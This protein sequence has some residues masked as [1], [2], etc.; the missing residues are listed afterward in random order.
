MNNKQKLLNIVKNLNL[1]Q[2]Q[3]NELVNVLSS[4][5]GSGKEDK[6]FE[7]RIK[8]VMDSKD[9]Y[10]SEFM[11]NGVG[12]FRGLSNNGGYYPDTLNGEP[13]DVN[14]IKNI[15]KDINSYTKLK[16]VRE[17]DVLSG[18]TIE[19]LVVYNGT[20]NDTIFHS[21]YSV[22]IPSSSGSGLGFL[23]LT[24]NDTEFMLFIQPD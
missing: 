19:N 20:L 13:Y 11:I 5:L 14:I 3:Q 9:Y 17:D 10:H 22:T 12:W 4:G 6:V 2:S 1:T 8:D 21:I 18:S 23:Y 24:Y 15:F 16:I 7:I